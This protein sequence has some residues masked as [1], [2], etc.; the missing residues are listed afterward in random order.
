M[1]EVEINSRLGFPEIPR[2]MMRHYVPVKSKLKH[3]PA[4][5]GHLTPL[6]AQEGGR[7]ITTLWGGEFDR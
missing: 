5:P 3:S 4:Y 6:P 1:D 7:L 2:N